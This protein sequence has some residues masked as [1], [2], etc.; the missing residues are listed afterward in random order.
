MEHPPASKTQS[1]QS[2]SGTPKGDHLIV[3]LKNDS[4]R[5]RNSLYSEQVPHRPTAGPAR[6]ATPVQTVDEC[7]LRRKGFR[8]AHDG[9]VYYNGMRPA[10]QFMLSYS[11]EPEL[12]KTNLALN[13][14]DTFYGQCRSTVRRE[15]EEMS[16]S[17]RRKGLD[18]A[19]GDSIGATGTSICMK[20]LRCTTHKFEAQDR[21][22]TG[23]ECRRFRR[24]WNRYQ[25]FYREKERP[26]H[27]SFA[28]GEGGGVVDADPDKFRPKGDV[29]SSA[30]GPAAV[31][32]VEDINAIRDQNKAAGKLVTSYQ[33]YHMT[34]RHS[35]AGRKRTNSLKSAIYAAVQADSV[36]QKQQS[37][38]RMLA[39][40]QVISF[41]GDIGEIV[42]Q[43]LQAERTA[44]ALRAREENIRRDLTDLHTGA[45]YLASKYRSFYEQAVIRSTNTAA[46]TKLPA[47]KA[48]PLKIIKQRVTSSPEKS[49]ERSSGSGASL[50]QTVQKSAE[51]E[52]QVWPRHEPGEKTYIGEENALQSAAA[53]E[54]SIEIVRYLG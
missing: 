30:V 36:Q 50:D 52:E 46:K 29:V 19:S 17:A 4:D 10:E 26:V 13:V 34:K 27:I 21:C 24:K 23:G 28:G 40:G 16:L 49:A 2:A 12:R 9:A 5:P 51:V 44:A 11:P 15:T 54:K 39:I 35:T 33:P 14:K 43:K 37:E 3:R 8:V 22:G 31:P 48:S 45:G 47:M 18:T 6:V 53:I 42:S 38:R 1:V 41:R 25:L 7:Q 20:R 32:L